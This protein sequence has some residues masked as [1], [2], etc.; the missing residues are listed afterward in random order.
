MAILLLS[1]GNKL[2]YIIEQCIKCRIRKYCQA[3]TGCFYPLC[4]I[5]IP[6]LMRCFRHSGFPLQP[7]GIDTT[8]FFAHI[9]N[10]RNG[11]F[12]IDAQMWC[13]KYIIYDYPS[14]WY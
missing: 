3:T 5:R 2:Y 9:I 6:E 14:E 7:I 13:P 4:H 11:L 1:R 10:M 12:T 8:G